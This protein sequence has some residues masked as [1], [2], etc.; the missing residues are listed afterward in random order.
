MD[1]LPEL[2]TYNALADLLEQMAALV[3]AGDS[4]EGF[5]EYLIPPMHTHDN[6][7][8]GGM[9]VDVRARYRVGNL[10]GQGGFIFIGQLVE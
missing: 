1:H 9:H 3:R 4:W 6:D 5:I 2:M 7:G 10:D 8:D